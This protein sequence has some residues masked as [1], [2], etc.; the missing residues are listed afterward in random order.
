MKTR[1]LVFLIQLP[2]LLFNKKATEIEIKIHNLTN[3]ATK[4]ALNAKATEVENKM[5]DTSTL[6]RKTDNNTKMIEIENKIPDLSDFDT[7]LRQIINKV[8]S[9]RKQHKD[10]LKQN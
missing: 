1:Y 3:L 5:T 2:L 7:K 8:M 4:A 6:V 9:T 10:I